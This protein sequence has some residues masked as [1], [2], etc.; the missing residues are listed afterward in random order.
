M[1]FP[2]SRRLSSS[3]AAALVVALAAVAASCGSSKSAPTTTI[4]LPQRV[5]VSRI[6]G[7]SES[8][9]FAS[10][11]EQA[12]DN[13]GLRVVRQNAV[14]DQATAYAGLQNGSLQVVPEY[15]G[16]FLDYLHSI[17]ATP[18][19][20]TVAPSTTSS[21]T[22]DSTTGG[23]TPAGESSTS[24][25]P[26]DSSTSSTVALPVGPPRTIDEQVALIKSLLPTTI[27]V[28]AVSTAEHKQVIACSKAAT[29]AHVLGT[30][31]DLGVNADVLTLGGPAGFETSTPMGI[32]T[33]K[34]AYHANFKK[35]VELASDKI[36]AAVKDGTIDCAVVNSTDPLIAGQSMTTLLDDKAL[37][38]PNG[39]IA[40]VS[41]AAATPEVLAA[42]DTVTAKM[43]TQVLAGM[44]NEIIVKGTSPD[45]LAS[46]FL[47][48]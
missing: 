44:M 13:A 34:S 38:P 6:G 29:D 35:F 20:T 8:S 24:T 47:Q 27:T 46:E 11:Y 12:L 31:T 39:A 3:R 14:A 19:A 48:K 43:N 23:T 2:V 4:V 16:D 30:L 5:V 9:L 21:S 1:L 26:D 45:L 42:L 28:A 37:V 10:L 40:L 25:P 33:L 18:P 41:V 17:G 36:E 22:T 15:S 7:D 32:A